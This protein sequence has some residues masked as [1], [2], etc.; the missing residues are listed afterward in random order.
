MNSLAFIITITTALLCATPV[1]SDDLALIKT[2]IA[3]MCNAN[4]NDKSGTF[5]ECC[6]NNDIQAITDWSSLPACFSV[7]HDSNGYVT[8]WFVHMTAE[9]STDPRPA[10]SPNQ[11]VSKKRASRL[12]PPTR[13]LVSRC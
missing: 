3:L 9:R 1:A 7:T 12:S 4:P 5:G 10:H 11:G 2:K 6:K 13:S 8:K